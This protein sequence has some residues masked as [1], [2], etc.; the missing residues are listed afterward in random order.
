M[1][2]RISVV[3][4]SGAL[5]GCMG[6]AE[7]QVEDP[8]VDEATVSQGVSCSPQMNRFPVNAPHNIGYDGASCGSG[9]C[10]ISCPDQNANSDYGG[11]HHGIDVFAFHRAPIVA[12]ASG[13]I[14]RV[15]W[16]SSTSG[17]RVTLS[18]G[19]GWWY[20]YGHLDEAVV[21]EGQW[22]NAG[23]L[24]GFMGRSGAAST[25]L[26]FN[27]S[28]DGN[29]NNDIDPFGLLSSTSASACGGAVGGDGCN[30]AQ[31]DGCGQYG[32]GC[33]DGACNGVFCDGTGCT[34]GEHLACGQ[35]GSNCV[36]HNCNGGTA[37]GTGCTARETLN[38]AQYGSGCVD[39]QCNGGTSPGTGCT[40]RES[41]DCAQ[42]G[43][44]CVDHQCNGGTAPGTGC[45]W[46]ETH[47]CA[48]YGS[49]CVDHQCNGGT[50]PGSGCTWRET[51]ECT[52]QGAGC[53]DHKC[54]GGTAA[55]TGCTWRQTYDCQQQGKAC[56]LGKCV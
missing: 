49:G 27:V 35:Y 42:Y 18:D 39:H 13:T 55:G 56:S 15:G 28:A 38:C 5:A 17:L 52:N 19:C 26:H 29:Y 47:D 33:V 50:A 2:A 6:S 7:I 41:H 23:D 48:Q 12:V 14:R 22:V 10:D 1:N 24:I 36:D 51:Q 32:C 53:A 9:T 43:S 46:R 4:I 34:Y 45:T 30:Q 16:P 54:S 3:L 25:H 44:N 21:G 8:L 31:R 20:Y 11:V 37:P 40:W